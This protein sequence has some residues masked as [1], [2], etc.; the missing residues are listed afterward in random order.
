MKSKKTLNAAVAGLLISGATYSTT[1]KASGTKDAPGG[2]NIHC[3]G[4]A[5]KYVNDCGANGHKCGGQAA[6][7]FQK[8][9]WLK[10]SKEDCKAVKTAI[11]NPAIKRYLERIQKGTAAAVKSGKKI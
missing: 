4:V 5:M 8:G 2:K 11:K 6:S 1:V 10:M 3:E 9:E 7:N